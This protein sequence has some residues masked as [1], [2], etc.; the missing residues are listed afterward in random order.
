MRLVTTAVACLL[1]NATVASACSV[2][3]VVNSQPSS[4]RVQ[5]KILQNGNP[6]KDVKIEVF[7]M[8]NQLRLF[9]LSTNDQG[10]ATLPTLSPARYLIAATAV[11]GLGADLVLDVS[12]G[13]G[14]KTSLFSMELGVRPPP[15]PTIEEK[16]T[17]AEKASAREAV[18]E[19][20][21]ILQDPSGA[22]VTN[23]SVDV[24]PKGS[25]DKTQALEIKTDESGRFSAFLADGTY[26]ALFQA[27]GFQTEIVV[28]EISADAQR[29]EL[30]TV[31][32][33][34]LCN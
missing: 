22:G 7:T 19:F 8:D 28:L 1:L 10:V 16:M 26:T 12:K 32:K 14:H 21:G 6:I 33:L 25:R 9:S 34:G 5:I 15:P 11:G 30:Q 27:P 18:K 17:G 13:L 2:V 3:V 23:A 29:K 24:Y 31:L 4:Q 20:R